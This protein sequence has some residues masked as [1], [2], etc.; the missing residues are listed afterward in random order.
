MSLSMILKITLELL[1]NLLHRESRPDLYDYTDIL[2]IPIVN[3]DGYTYINN[4]Y[5]KSDWDSAKL[6]RKN[7]N[8]MVPCR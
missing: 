1:Y 7:F 2:I 8:L 5:N 3:L 6:K 4:H